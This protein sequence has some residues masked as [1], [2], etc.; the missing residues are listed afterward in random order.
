LVFSLS[1]YINNYLYNLHTFEAFVHW[2]LYITSHKMPCQSGSTFAKFSFIAL[3][4][5]LTNWCYFKIQLCQL[6]ITK[7]SRCL[8]CKGRLVFSLSIYI[9]NYLFTCATHWKKT[10]KIFNELHYYANLSQFIG[11]EQDCKHR[12]YFVINNWHIFWL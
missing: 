9:N 11:R 3:G 10:W 12:L 6:F 8:Q 1:I 4:R 5:H 2:F 7:Y